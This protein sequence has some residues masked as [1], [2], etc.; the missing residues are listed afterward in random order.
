[1]SPSWSPDGR[2]IAYVSF[3]GHA[4]AIY[5]Q[6]VQSGARELVAEEPGINSAPAFSPDGSRLALTLSKDGNPEV[7]VMDLGSRALKRI[8][9]DPGI[10]TEPSW[11]PDGRRIA[12]TSDRGGGPQIYET[13]VS[14]DTPRRLT[15]EGDYNARPRYS[16]DGT[17]LAL[18]HGGDRGYRI[19]T[20]DLAS[21]RLNILTDTRLDES[22]SFAPNGGMIIYATVGSRGTELAAISVDGRIR[23]QIAAGGGEVREPAWGPFRD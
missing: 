3:E 8:T 5:V 11:S 23:Q 14:G 6:E 13:S 19:A 20:L 4:S 10:D 15:H 12:F 16:A 7:Y 17:L 1:M 2:R 21:E 18:V 22:P 9:H